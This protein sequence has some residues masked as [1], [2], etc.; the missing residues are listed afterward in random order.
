MLVVRTT[1]IWYLIFSFAEKNLS[2]CKNL[3]NCNRAGSNI[4]TRKLVPR[5]FVM[6]QTYIHRSIPIEMRTRVSHLKGYAPIAICIYP[7]WILAMLVFNARIDDSRS[8]GW[9][10]TDT[11]RGIC[12]KMEP[13]F[14]DL[15]LICQ[16]CQLPIFDLHKFPGHNL[17]VLLVV[18]IYHIWTTNMGDLHL[19]PGHAYWNSTITW[20]N[21]VKHWKSTLFQYFA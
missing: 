4:C 10:W 13:G 15:A 7:I 12:E 21:D 6:Y 11:W 9:W 19:S 5:G 18:Q 14:N 3:G 16:M 1:N 8:Q 2:I 17:W 20:K